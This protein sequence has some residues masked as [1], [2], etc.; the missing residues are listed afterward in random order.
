MR[1]F[2]T[3][4]VSGIF[5]AG[6]SGTTLIDTVVA[7]AILGAVAVTFLSGLATASRAT[8]TVDEQA[9]AE[10]IARSQMEWVKSVLYENGA[11]YYTAA[12]LPGDPEY[13]SYSVEITAAPVHEEDDGIQKIVVVV[14]HYGEEV[15]RLE[16]YKVDR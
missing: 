2:R 6:Q 8:I 3:T 13:A 14:R 16:D 7:L 10:S 11:S 4:G 9:T 12:A 15:A 1:L 5:A